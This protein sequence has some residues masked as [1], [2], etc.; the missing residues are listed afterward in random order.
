MFDTVVLPRERD[1][2]IRG[3]KNTR[4]KLKKTHGGCYLLMFYDGLDKFQGIKDTESDM[5]YVKK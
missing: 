5:F 3:D 4:F 1:C 2:V